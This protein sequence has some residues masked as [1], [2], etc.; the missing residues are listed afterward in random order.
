MRTHLL[1]V[2][3]FIAASLPTIA[4]TADAPVAISLP[5]IDA[6]FKDF[7]A[8]T[9]G[10]ALGIYRAGQVLYAKGYGMADLDLG[11]PIR[12][13]TVFDIGSTSK[14]F[15]A[16]AIVLLAND[17]KLKFADDVRKYIPELPDYG[18]VITVDNLLQHT[19]GLRD[20]DGLLFLAGHYY[21]DVTS[22][23]DALAIIKSQ[24]ALNFTPGSRWSYSNTGFFLLALIVKRV[25]GQGLESF[26]KDRLFTPLGMSVTHFRTQHAA[27]LKNRAVA[28]EA[29]ASAGFRIDM[30]NWDQIGDG[31]VQ[32]NVLDLAQWD[33]EFYEP[34]VGSRAFVDELQ[35][36]AT[37][38]DGTATQYGRGLFLDTY[39]GLRRVHHGGAWAGYRAMLMRFPEQKLAIGLT[40]NIDNADPQRRA[41]A[42]ADVVLAGAFLA[43]KMVPDEKTTYAGPKYDAQRVT[44]AYV[45]DGAQN[46][47]RISIANGVLDLK[48]GRRTFH[49]GQ[50]GP[51]QFA[52][53]DGSRSIDMGADDQSFVFVANGTTDPVYRRVRPYSASPNDVAALAGSYHSPEL[54]TDWNIRVEGGRAYING[55]AIGE[56]TLEP[57]TKESWT[58][59]PSFFAF[60]RDADDRIS[61]FDM[62]TSRMMRIHFDRRPATSTSGR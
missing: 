23:D 1:G 52:T 7:G 11:V 17:G 60:T 53:S 35:E 3:C 12:P 30:S 9:P 13:E 24:R 29:G 4:W 57:V 46:A 31:G 28:Y 55:R 42:V 25:S 48:T 38:D 56:S 27:V 20:Y 54:A 50:V 41:E 26:A 59:G 33:A 47:L 15:T 10:C 14:Q 8:T 39:R 62:S 51:R 19:S 34:R 36:R 49:L 2:T 21:E 37:L 44:G 16:A 40:C 43:P 61:G 58:S 32:T 22:D 6:V 5:R 45:S 18:H